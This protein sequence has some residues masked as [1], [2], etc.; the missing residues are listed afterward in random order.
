[1]GL[2]YIDSNSDPPLTMY[3][4]AGHCPF[5]SLAFPI[6]KAQGLD[7]MIFYISYDFK[8]PFRD[9]GPPGDLKVNGDGLWCSR[10]WGH[11]PDLCMDD[12]HRVWSGG[13]ALTSLPLPQT[14]AVSLSLAPGCAI[15]SSRHCAPQPV[16]SPTC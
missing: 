4:Q 13:R 11:V 7:Q 6:C 14:L 5:Q 10:N 16:S 2:W 12:M 8:I 15:T 9:I 3:P 1:M